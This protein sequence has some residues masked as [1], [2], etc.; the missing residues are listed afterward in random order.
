M[1]SADAP[2][3]AGARRWS[4]RRARSS[5]VKSDKSV[6]DGARVHAKD[7][8]YTVVLAPAMPYRH[9]HMNDN[10]TQSQ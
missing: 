10:G 6:R 4:T 7:R 9:E 3:T 5:D 2:G 1:S 8:V